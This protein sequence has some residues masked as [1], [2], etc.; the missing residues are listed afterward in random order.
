MDW[1]Q[2]IAPILTAI[3]AVIMAWFTYNQR[4]KDKLTDLR[5]E[6][7]WQEKNRESKRR[8][9]NSSIIFGELWNILHLLNADRVYIVQ[10]HPL[11]REERLSIWFEVKRKGVEPMKPHIQNLDIS[12]VAV[13]N[14]MLT[15]NLF[16]YL[17]DIDKQVD[18]K[19]AKSILSSYGCCSA[20]IKRLS[21]SKHDRN[22]N[23]FCEFTRSLT[24]SEN[25]AHEV[26]H[27]AA[28]NIQYILPPIEDDEP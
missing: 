20:I 14:R 5:I 19:Y 16:L 11:G 22:G 4:T 17:T 6:K 7:W 24:I 13:F 10:P 3:G 28:T 25:E 8:S 21:D 23:I 9:D 26:L 12:E 2:Y 27:T 15:E 18:D 1:V